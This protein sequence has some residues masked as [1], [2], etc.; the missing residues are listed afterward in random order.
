MSSITPVIDNILD[1]ITGQQDK[2]TPNNMIQLRG[3]DLRFKL[4]DTTQGVFFRSG[5]DPEVRA[6]MYGQNEPGV[7][8]AAIPAAL[9]GPLQVRIAAYINGSVRSYTY[10]HLITAV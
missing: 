3:D 4:S 2:Y 9:S 6:S 7:V 1:F 8:T 10:T 5:S